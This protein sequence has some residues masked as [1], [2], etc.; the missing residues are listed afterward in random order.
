MIM[1]VLHFVKR[2]FETL[3]VH[4][5]SLA[6]MPFRNIFKNSAHYWIL[7]GFNMAY[8]I[9]SPTAP[10]AGPTNSLLLYL[11][12]AH[13]VV[14]ELGNLYTHLVL[15]NLRR[16][17]STERGI[18]QGLGFNLVTC[19]NY[20]FEIMAWVGVL[21]VSCSLSTLLFLVVSA[22]QIFAWGKKKERRYRKEFGDKYKRKRFVVLPGV[23]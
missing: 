9:Y 2:E 4:R 15:R 18:P 23:Y 8:W 5:F 1:V 19:P 10:T 16:P 22:A 13:Y 12:I 20:M 11:G 17:G 6:T 14:G 7:S 3:F 21:M